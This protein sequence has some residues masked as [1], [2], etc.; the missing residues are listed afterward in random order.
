MMLF[1][2]FTTEHVMAVTLGLSYLLPSASFLP[3]TETANCSVF[4]GVPAITGLGCFARRAIAL[5]RGSL[6]AGRGMSGAV[7]FPNASQR[8]DF[9]LTRYPADLREKCHFHPAFAGSPCFLLNSCYVI[10]TAIK[11][12]PYTTYSLHFIRTR[13]A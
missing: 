7:R 12:H 3:L 9:S 10:Y 4:L 6:T 5:P 8:L 13:K 2:Y 11:S 1:K